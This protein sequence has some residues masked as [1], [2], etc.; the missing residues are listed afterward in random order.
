MLNNKTIQ[1]YVC[2]K[3]P[4]LLPDKLDRVKKKIEKKK[5]LFIVN[6]NLRTALQN[7]K[8][9]KKYKQSLKICI[10]YALVVF[11]YAVHL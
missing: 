7:W 8:V 10:M 6:Q 2:H 4:G 5:R 9:Q 11:Y 1:K 3:Y